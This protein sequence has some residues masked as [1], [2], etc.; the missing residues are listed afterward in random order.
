MAKFI[1]TSGINHYLEELIKEANQNIILVSPYLKFNSKIKELIEQKLNEGVRLTII[2]GKSKLNEAE[3]KW[4]NSLPN[5]TISF[6]QNLHAKCYL[7]E[8]EAIITSMNLYEFSQL[9]NDE[10]GIHVPNSDGENKE[11]F[12]D[13]VKDVKRILSAVTKNNKS[14]EG[15]KNTDTHSVQEVKEQKFDSAKK[16][17]TSKLAKLHKV[18]T[19]EILEMLVNNGFLEASNDKKSLTQK[20]K[21]NGGEFKFSPKN[22]PYF[23]WP[24]SLRL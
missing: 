11:L 14:K 9:N 6:R 15:S 19:D 13:I 2:Y 16:V 4:L 20:G 5:T 24:E 3:E 22:G 10:M 18:K 1:S 12:I 21:D 17:T 23:L 8:K 7:S